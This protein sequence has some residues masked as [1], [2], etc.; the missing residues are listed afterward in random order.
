MNRIADAS[1]VDF[2]AIESD[3]P[4]IPHYYAGDYFSQSGFTGAVLSYK[5][6]NLAAPNIET[7][8]IKSLDAAVTFAYILRT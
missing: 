5:G 4:G 8:I 3:V 1:K 2:L 7:Y 6:K